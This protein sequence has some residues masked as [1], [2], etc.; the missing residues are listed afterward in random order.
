M[1]TKR[2]LG[3]IAGLFAFAAAMATA[4]A[5][6]QDDVRAATVDALTANP[7]PDAPTPTVTVDRSAVH[8]DYVVVAG[9]WSFTSWKIVG[10]PRGDMVL[11]K[12]YNVWHEFGRGSPHMSAHVLQRFGVPPPIVVTFATGACPVPAHSDAA[13]YTVDGVSVRRFDGNGKRVDTTAACH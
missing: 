13:G 8:I 4:S 1:R 9:R 7:N 3:A 10:G 11:M 6:V 5:S 2:R 12:T